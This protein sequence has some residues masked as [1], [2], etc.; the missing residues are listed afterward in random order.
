MNSNPDDK[1]SAASTSIDGVI[2]PIRKSEPAIVTDADVAAIGEGVLSGTH[3]YLNWTHLAHCAATLYLLVQKPNWVL[4][5]KMPDIIRNYNSAIGVA[6]TDTTGY[7]E[8]LTIF[9]I[10][11]IRNFLATDGKSL[12]PAV[13]LAALQKSPIGPTSSFF[14]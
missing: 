5:E 9:Y 11:A 7:H 12:G 1:Q 6:N 2:R 3:P 13:A 4:E 8:T 14:R 10:H